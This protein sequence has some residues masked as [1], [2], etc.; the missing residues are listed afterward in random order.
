MYSPQVSCL[1]AFLLLEAETS[2]KAVFL[3]RGSLDK[4]DLDLSAIE[5]T[6]TDLVMYDKTGPDNVHERLQEASIVIVNKVVL[7]AELI[8]SLPELKLICI[9]ATGTNNV[10]LKQAAKQGIVVSNCQGYGTPSVVQH[11]LCLM[12][13]LATRL[14]DYSAAVQRGDWNRSEQFCLMDYPIME[15]AGKTLGIVGYGELGQEVARL[16]DALG[17]KVLI[18]ARP[19][20]EA[21]GDRLSLEQLLPQVD[22]LTLHCPLTEQSQNLIDSRAFGLM[23]PGAFLINAARG[24]IVDEQALAD[25]LTSGHLGGAAMDVLSVEPPANGNLLLD[26]SIPNLIL[27]PHSAWASLEARQRIVTQIAEN[28]AAYQQSHPIRTV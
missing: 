11:T 10:D 22:L 13:A 12:L 5:R 2:M 23:K 8:A 26:P 15:L 9:A 18:S 4:A 1:R 25:A 3:D 24:G 27:T 19:G 16:A 6:V 7:D 21:T 20:T 14:Q 17:M 28:I